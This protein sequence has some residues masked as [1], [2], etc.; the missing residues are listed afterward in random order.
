MEIL[1]DCNVWIAKSMGKKSKE[2]IMKAGYTPLIIN[3]DTIQEAE[4]EI[5]K[6]LD[7]QSFL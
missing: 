5:V 2:V 7:H 6:A 4:K 1:S 3:S